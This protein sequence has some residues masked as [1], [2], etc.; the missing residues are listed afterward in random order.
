MPVETVLVVPTTATVAVGASFVLAAEARD[1]AGNLL[2]DR[3]TYWSAEDQAVAL[4]SETGRVTARQVGTVQV[5]ASIEGKSGFATITVTS[6]PVATVTLTPSNATLLVGDSVQMAAQTRDANGAVLSGRPI[7]WTSSNPTVATVSATGLVTAIGSGASIISA[8]SEG[9]SALASV[10][11]SSVPVASVT[12]TP[13][14][15]TIVIGQTTQLTAAAADASG[16]ALPGRLVTWTTSSSATATVSTSG[17]VTAVAAGTATIT[18][19]S[20]GRSATSAI[21]VVAA[22]PATV[23]VTPATAT[24]DIGQQLRLDAVVKDHAGNVI[25]SPSITWTSSDTRVATVNSSG[26]VT[27]RFPGTATIT[28]TSG[29]AKGTASITVRLGG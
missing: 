24:I 27:G 17:L 2:D 9:K 10:N 6:T 3:R 14:S 29:S 13:V 25:S 5:A 18:A 8:E 12:V 20:E 4:V 21:T 28:A 16:N 19:T 22:G 23:T 11:V 7:A 1:V 26:R 15:T